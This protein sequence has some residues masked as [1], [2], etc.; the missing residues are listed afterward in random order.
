MSESQNLDLT[1]I[2]EDRTIDR[3]FDLDPIKVAAIA[4]ESSIALNNVF[5]DFDKAVLKPESF[6]ELNR[7]VNMMMER[8][9]MQV[10]V[11]GHTDATGPERYNLELSRRRAEAVVRYLSENG[12]PKNR[13]SVKFFGENN[14]IE[15]NET[16][17]GRSR[18][19]R[20]EFKIVKL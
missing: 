18:N 9:T 10:E 6:P 14:P 20:V 12:V 16:P 13:L 11:E 7:L 1:A 15:T 17:V 19:R 8:G 2:K 5:F 4:E 3:D